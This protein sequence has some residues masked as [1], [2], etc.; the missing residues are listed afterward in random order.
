MPGSLEAVEA[1]GGSP[2]APK[3][4]AAGA[5]AAAAA[6]AAAEGA[7]RETARRGACAVVGSGP[8]TSRYHVRLSLSAQPLAREVGHHEEKNIIKG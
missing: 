3:F 7:A 5:A 1:A 4:A 8:V 6:A 2:A